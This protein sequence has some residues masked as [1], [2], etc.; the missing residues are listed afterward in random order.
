MGIHATA[1]GNGRGRMQPRGRVVPPRGRGSDRGRW[2]LRRRFVQPK[3]VTK[4]DE[5]KTVKEANP[6]GHVELSKSFFLRVKHNVLQK[7][8]PY[9]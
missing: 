7:S 6:P 3:K 1:R 4:K 5:K 9:I 8:W 2:N